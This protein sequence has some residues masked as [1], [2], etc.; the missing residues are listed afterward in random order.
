LRLA[1][2]NG[3][4]IR[5]VP[6]SQ[7]GQAYDR[8]SFGRGPDLA[9]RAAGALPPTTRINAAP[10]SVIYAP[11]IGSHAA[12]VPVPAQKP[13]AAVAKSAQPAQHAAVNEA[14]PAAAPSQPA[15]TIG[16]AKPAAPQVNAPQVK[17]TQQM[18]A[19]QGLE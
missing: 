8:M 17:P 9:P 7:W 3:R 11:S 13:A 12:A 15:G 2:R 10:P 16:E 4:I 18:P 14:K 1:G 19:V 5:V 6:A